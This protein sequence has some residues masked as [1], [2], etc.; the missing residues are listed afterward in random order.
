MFVL[1][2]FFFETD[3]RRNREITRGSELSKPA[4][5]TIFHKN[6]MLHLQL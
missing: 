3:S 1:S 2:I 6:K 4:H 5:K